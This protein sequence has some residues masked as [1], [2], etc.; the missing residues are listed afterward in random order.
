MLTHATHIT[1]KMKLSF[2][3]L[4]S[5]IAGAAAAGLDF[6]SF[7]ASSKAAQNLI[8]SSLQVEDSFDENSSRQ[9][10]DSIDENFVA[11]HSIYFDG[12]HNTTS[13][14]EDG[15]A[16]ISLVRFRLCPTKYIH[17]GRCFS[18]RVGEYLVQMT[19]FVDAYMEFKLESVR[20]QCE[21]LREVCGCDDQDDDG[22]LYHCYETYGNGLTDAQC[23]D[24]Q[25]D[26]ERY[27]ECQRLEI[28]NDDDAR[29]LEDNEQ[30]IFMGPY[31]GPGGTGV[32]LT[33]FSDEDCSYTLPGAAGYYSALAGT[34]MP[35]LYT[36]GATGM[37]D[38]GWTSCAEQDDDDDNNNNNDDARA[39]ELCEDSYTYA[40]KCETNM[41]SLTY[42]DTRACSYIATLK[43]EGGAA[44]QLGS[45]LTAMSW[46]AVLFIVAGVVTLG[47]VSAHVRANKRSKSSSKTVPL[48]EVEMSSS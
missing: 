33:L 20:Q 39:I 14:S 9:L 11:S 22:C 42:P 38:Q 34:E 44:Y 15:Y 24:E 16:I 47:A 2:S 32:F 21:N 48:V 26:E 41:T 35:Y 36:A 4:A 17:S 10:E 6:V 19:T 27:G 40:A 1:Q 23:D 45:N 12:C 13:W 7:D 25:G 31:C 28:E 30:E 43:A 46:V 8:L 37:V 5:A 3:L 18:R 29:R